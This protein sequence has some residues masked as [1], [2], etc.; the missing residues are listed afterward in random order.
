MIDWA[1]IIEQHGPDVWR[2]AYRLL[3][4]RDEASDCYQE[5]FLQA[6]EYAGGHSVENWAGVLRRIATA[7]ALDRLR[8]RYR[9]PTEPLGDIPPLDEREP[10]PDE[11]AQLREWMDQLRAALTQ[12]PE[13]Q[14]EAFWLC[15]VEL[16]GRDDV[17]RQLDASPK[18]VA[19]WLHRAKRKLR[20]LLARQGIEKAV[21][22]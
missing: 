21:E 1:T 10:S 5:T 13:S 18:Q 16:L 19:V 8:R 20:K 12:L 2:T 15:E 22:Q 4:D 17:A 9:R 14:A 3:T 7:R 6:V 11:P